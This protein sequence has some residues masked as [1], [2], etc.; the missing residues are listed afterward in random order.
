MRPQC[1]AAHGLAACLTLGA[2]KAG[3]SERE[4]IL[5]ALGDECCGRE[6]R[7]GRGEPE[8]LG[9][10]RRK[11]RIR[12]TAHSKMRAKKIVSGQGHSD[13]Q[14]CV[15]GGKGGSPSRKTGSLPQASSL[16]RQASESDIAYIAY[17][18]QNS[19]ERINSTSVVSLPLALCTWKKFLACRRRL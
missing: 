9:M 12:V 13:E 4:S 17:V 15:R 10:V 2:E 16:V 8:K 18:R 1:S 14:Q 5:G 11:I 6:K 7:I 19:H 3:A